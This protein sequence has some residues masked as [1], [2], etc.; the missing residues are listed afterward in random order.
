MSPPSPKTTRSCA[1]CGK[2]QQPEFRPFCSQRCS[3]IDLGRWLKGTYVIPDR[4]A[5]EGV[6]PL[7]PS[8]PNDDSGDPG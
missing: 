4:S 2:P 7:A 6:R 3:N 1:I 8:N 5:D